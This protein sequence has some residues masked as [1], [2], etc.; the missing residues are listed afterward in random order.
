M[1]K[2]WFLYL[3]PPIAVIVVVFLV[4]FWRQKNKVQPQLTTSNQ[5]PIQ[6]VGSYDDYVL[7]CDYQDLH[8]YSYNQAPVLAG[9]WR[10][11][12]DISCLYLNAKNQLET[13]Y[14][15][16]WVYQPDSQQSLMAGYTFKSETQ[17]GIAKSG[18]K[19]AILTNWPDERLRANET[20]DA[21]FKALKSA[22]DSL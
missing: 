1:K 11:L 3:V 16:F 17:F 6:P 14:L 19:M 13:I 15:P 4:L 12:V 10:S 18:S 2:Q 7:R 20:Q 9:N 22:I 8:L 5:W 21:A